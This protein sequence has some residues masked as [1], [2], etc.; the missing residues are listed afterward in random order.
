MSAVDIAI[1]VPVRDFPL[2]S[3]VDALVSAVDRWW[4]GLPPPLTDHQFGATRPPATDAV[5]HPLPPDDDSPAARDSGPRRGPGRGVEAAART[6]R[7][8]RR[9]GVK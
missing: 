5:T 7:R 3:H 4:G 2:A 8:G 9:R 1:P 6:S